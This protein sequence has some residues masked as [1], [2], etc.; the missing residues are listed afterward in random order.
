MN[1]L[2]VTISGIAINKILF[3][4]SFCA[5]DLQIVFNCCRRFWVKFY[6]VIQLAYWIHSYPELYF[7]KI[8][9]VN[10]SFAFFVL[11]NGSVIYSLL[12]LHDT[13]CKSHAAMHESMEMGMG[14]CVVGMGWGR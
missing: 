14:M 13:Y 11:P 12:F 10:Q 1:C 6:F 4:E 7:Q 2:F 8:K 3:S 5:I 9:K